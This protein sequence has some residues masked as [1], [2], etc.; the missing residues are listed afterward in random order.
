MPES[1]IPAATEEDFKFLE[2]LQNR[3]DG[4]EFTL[5]RWEFSSPKSKAV[6]VDLLS[7]I[8]LV[9]H[10]QREAD[11]LRNLSSKIV[12]LASDEGKLRIGYFP[13]TLCVNS[14]GVPGRESRE[15]CITGTI[16]DLANALKLESVED[17]AEDA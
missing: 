12:N 1:N 17:G 4:T 6:L 8:R 5:Q 3:F 14:K 16:Q 15:F 7:A 13:V 11:L 10:F 2:K 9:A